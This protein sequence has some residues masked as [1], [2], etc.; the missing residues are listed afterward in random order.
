MNITR[1]AITAIA[2]AAGLMFGAGGVAFADVTSQSSSEEPADSTSREGTS[3]DA[4]DH[5][6]NNGPGIV[7]GDGVKTVQKIVA[8]IPQFDENGDPI[9]DEN[10]KQV[11][12]PKWATVPI[13]KGLPDAEIFHP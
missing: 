1:K 9:L 6:A 2:L 3:A 11:T 4:V 8:W 10:G 12:K 13:G 7:V 5:M